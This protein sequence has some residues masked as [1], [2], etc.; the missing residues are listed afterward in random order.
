MEQAQQNMHRDS[1]CAYCAR[2][3]RGIMYA[4]AR[5]QG[6]RVLALAQHLDDLAESFLMSAFYEG[7]LHTMK[8]HYLNDAGDVR[9][10]RP[11]VYIRERQT[12]E[13][14]KQV[15]LPVI[16]DNCPACFTQPTQR[17]HIKALLL[18]EELSHK[19][20]FKTILHTMRPLMGS[21]PSI[22]LT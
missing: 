5:Q 9:V 10:I 7:R 1:F 11:L 14:A 16:T 22:D 15:R 6:Y 4:T 19:Q 20:L 18:Q 3:K 13:F 8:A 12:A 17:A 21:P 2:M